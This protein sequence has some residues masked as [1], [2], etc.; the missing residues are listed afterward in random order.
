MGYLMA[1]L[2][3]VVVGLAVLGYAGICIAL[4]AFQ[5][6]MIYFPQARGYGTASSVQTLEVA[7][8]SVQ[9]S[10][11]P[12]EGHKALIYFGGNAEDVSLNLPEYSRAFAD[13][14][15][16]LLHY[17]GYAG[18]TGRPTE[19]ALH[20]D[21]LA[22]FDHVR[23]RH[24]DVLVIGRSL[25][26]GVA[27]RLASLQPVSRL[28]LI[29]PYDSMLNLAQRQY[30]W[31]PIGWLLQDKFE[32]WR[33]AANVHATTSIL[34]AGQDQVIPRASSEAL[35]RSFPAGVSS[36][37]I[38]RGVDHNSISGHPDFFPA[39]AEPVAYA[40]SSQSPAAR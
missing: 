14:S 23:A 15:L 19:K 9:I 38:I 28:V 12:R 3:M 21:A 34:V 4:F 36:I 16:Y 27:V 30:P 25:G 5:R 22:L 35:H 17:R 18:S 10:I 24:S 6:S 11:R 39:M 33:H 26:S 13:R 32:S 7:D 40:V 31:L 2:A 1:R 37:R 20:A 29:T 8:V